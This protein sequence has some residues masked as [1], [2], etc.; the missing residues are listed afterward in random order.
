MSE[1]VSGRTDQ[2]TFSAAQEAVGSAATSTYDAGARAARY[3]SD[4]TSEHPFPVLVGVAIAAF[5]T[6]ILSASGG[7]DKRRDWHDARNWRDRGRE[8]A[9]HRAW[10]AGFDGGEELALE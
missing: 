3:V 8:M 6:G 7:S 9:Q 2:G 4:T 1:N 5:L 10:S